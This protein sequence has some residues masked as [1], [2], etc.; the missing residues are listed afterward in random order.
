M[1]YSYNWLQ[2]LT[3]TK[4]SPEELRELVT[5]H[6]F[7]VEGLEKVGADFAGVVVGKILEIAKHPNADKLQLTKVDAG[8]E[9]LE[10]VCGARNIIVGDMVP[11]AMVGAKLPNGLEIKEAEIR[12][13]KS[14]GMLCAQDELGLGADHAGIFL[15]DAQ[16]KI[17][18][19]LADYLNMADS[20]LDIDI[21]PNRAHDCLSYVGMAREIVALETYHLNAKK[22]SFDYD[23]AGLILP[24]KKSKKVAVEIK[25][26]DLCSRYMAVVMEDIEVGESPAWMQAR[27]LTSGIRP[28]NNIVDATNYVMLELGQP[29]HA[30]D[31]DEIS[32]SKAQANIVV[33]RAKKG[34]KI[35]LLDESVK[36]LS[37]QDLV[38][39][40]EKTALAI[41]GVMGGKHSG[42]NA[43]T[44]TIVLESANFNATAVRKTRTTL[45]I[46]TDASDRFE[47]ELD[48]NLAEKAMVR[49]VEI[50]E[51]IAHGKME[52]QVDSY[53]KAIKPWKIKLDLAYVDR[54]LG[55][56]VPFKKIGQMLNLLDIKISGQASM[57]TLEIP[58]FRVDLK[59]PEDL[60]E[61]IG[62]IFGYQNIQPQPI[63]GELVAPKINHERFFE[64]KVKELLNGLG[65]DEIYNYSFYS[66]KDRSNCKLE[67]VPHLEL[68]N[69]MNPEQ[70]C[71]RVSLVPGILH[72]VKNNLK[73]YKSL[74]FF[75]SGR[76]YLPKGE[77]LPEERKKIVMA[78]VLEQDKN[79]ETFFASKGMVENLLEKIGVPK[80]AFTEI[81]SSM[82]HALGLWHP[83]R[84]AQLTVA[85]QSTVLGYIGEI[86]PF[87]LASFK[88]AK[89]VALVELD[90][91]LLL[92]NIVEDR[93]FVELRKYPTVVRDISMLT[94]RQV[95][96][97]EIMQAI[98]V[99]GGGLILDVELF[100]IFQKEEGNSV[101]YHIEI[102]NAERTLESA[103][104][105]SVM[106]KIQTSLAKNFGVAIRK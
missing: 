57:V 46:K 77:V 45:G 55:D 100:D 90:L 8:D 22:A 97:G 11:V 84:S 20:I 95:H 24:K 10:I 28:I 83:T 5:L 94:D 14:F 13:E 3:D 73:N 19:P 86:N 71:M 49:L 61:E 29:L 66:H 34:E 80:V 62:R 31:W 50:I 12:G 4:L 48:P 43:K 65:M 18:T 81:D 30:F 21:L 76:T 32:G 56:Q 53:P 60:I 75:E 17:G 7:E 98:K 38:I 70:Q 79:N 106:E 96:V 58:T 52:G 72:N 59:T 39:A 41:A 92:D 87:V 44:R 104:V 64:R 67:E 63:L 68:E 89:R 102:G 26:I 27:L 40:N 105:D 23:Y 16:A 103:E 88:I 9:I 69:P 35:T 74:A 25:D 101:A 15:L 33:R 54:L 99:A 93:Q 2:E 47:K 78:L 42:I 1:K 51:H 37:N 82:S 6:A 91:G 85:G 36:E